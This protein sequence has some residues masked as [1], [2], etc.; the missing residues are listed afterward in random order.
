VRLGYQ[1][2]ADGSRVGSYNGSRFA[3]IE[4]RY[5]DVVRVFDSYYGRG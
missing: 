2:P 1:F 4:R 5:A 3:R